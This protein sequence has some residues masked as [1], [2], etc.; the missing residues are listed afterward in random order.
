MAINPIFNNNM[1]DIKSLS[2][3]EIVSGDA[4]ILDFSSD[5]Y[6][7]YYKRN[8]YAYLGATG[9][10][11]FPIHN[12][13]SD[14]PDVI[15]LQKTFIQQDC[16]QSGLTCGVQ[17]KP[18]QFVRRYLFLWGSCLAL[19]TTGHLIKCFANIVLYRQCLF[20]DAL[21]KQSSR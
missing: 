7:I 17:I 2:I 8:V 18:N 3:L 16:H 19:T 6:V 14:K 11:S 21:R 13:I 5:Q 20:S 12:I 4:Q 1:Q 15:Y 9:E 10:C